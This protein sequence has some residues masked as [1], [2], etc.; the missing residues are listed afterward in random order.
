MIESVEPEHSFFQ[1]F[2]SPAVHP[3][4]AIESVLNAC[5]RFGI[6]NAIA[7][8]LDHLE[9]S[10]L[11]SDIVHDKKLQVFYARQRNYFPTEKSFVAPF[12]IIESSQKGDYDYDLI[13]EGFHLR[14]TA[15]GIYELV[16]VIERERLFETFLELVNRLPSIRVFWIKIAGDWEDR[17]REEF[18]ANEDLNT[19]ETIRSF[20]TTRQRD[21][22]ANGHVAVTVY[23]DPG[24]TNLLIDTHK[25]IK[26]LT[27]SVRMQRKM[28]ASL[29]GL[30]YQELRDF[31]SLEHG[32]YHW[33]YRPVRSMS[34]KR[35]IAA[36]KSDG[37]SLWKEHA[38]ALAP[39]ENSVC[40]H[41]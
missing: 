33:H 3:G 34:R 27:K 15:E 1:V 38:V 29:S 2:W 37:F 22:V 39:P 41:D 25:T 24:Q 26:V 8:E 21:T 5:L 11:P 6:K 17:G 4:E 13:R 16:A 31:H 40:D 32:Y 35:L 30:G 9:F 19:S 10:S 28:S 12:G 36:L 23:S 18:W 7:R 14:K 20:L